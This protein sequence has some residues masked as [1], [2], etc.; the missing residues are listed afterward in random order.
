M[1]KTLNNELND[2]ACISASN[3][4]VKKRRKRKKSVPIIVQ[5]LKP[6]VISKLHQLNKKVELIKKQETIDKALKKAKLASLENE[7]K[8]IGGLSV[9]QTVSKTREHFHGNVNSSKWI[10]SSL[11]T[12]AS[13]SE[14]KLRLLDVGALSMNYENQASWLQCTYI[15]LNPQKKGILK[16][17]FLKFKS[18]AMEEY[19]IIVLSLVLN[20]PGD[21]QVRGQMLVKATELCKTCGY[22]FVVLPLA[23]LSNSRYLTHDNFHVMMESLGH[24][25]IA[26]H[27]STKLSHKAFRKKSRLPEKC[28]FPKK[29]VQPG[30]NK[31][32]FCIVLQT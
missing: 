21:A 14:V 32:N 5:R 9:Y 10:I 28:D 24:S 8:Q 23:C 20:F 15:D 11:K 17:D 6:D 4:K 29:V 26:S 27:N 16:S 25:L 3:K 7:I 18:G 19:D 31:N 22:I 13:K 12:F 1:G 2:P 30:G